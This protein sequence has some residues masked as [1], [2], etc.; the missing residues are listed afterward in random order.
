MYDIS[1]TIEVL[2]F[3]INEERLVTF[4]NVVINIIKRKNRYTE[5]DIHSIDE[6]DKSLKKLW[7]KKRTDNNII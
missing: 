6:I 7:P 4:D 5:I 3:T 2:G 1:D